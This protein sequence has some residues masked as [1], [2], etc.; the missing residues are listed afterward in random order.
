MA[1][2]LR[3]YSRMAVITPAM[4]FKKNSGV[5][6][7][8]SEMSDLASLIYMTKVSGSP[9]THTR[10]THSTVS[11]LKYSHPQARRLDFLV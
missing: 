8:P 4:P 11:F 6:L 10:L 9:L 3:T 2:T 1:P 7:N 5:I